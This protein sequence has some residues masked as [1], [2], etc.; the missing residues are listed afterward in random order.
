MEN[1][2]LSPY[3]PRFVGLNHFTQHCSRVVCQAIPPKAAVPFFVRVYLF[4][5]EFPPARLG[6]PKALARPGGF[7]I[8]LK[9]YHFP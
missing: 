3:N 1:F 8:R 6:E 9:S 7:F 2:T 4:C 5:S